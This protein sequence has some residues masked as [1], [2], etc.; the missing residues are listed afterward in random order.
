M[1]LVLQYAWRFQP[2][3]DVPYASDPSKSRRPSPANM[4]VSV[5]QTGAYIHI[6]RRPQ[7]ALDLR[8]FHFHPFTKSLVVSSIITNQSAP[9]TIQRFL[10]Q[11]SFN[12]P[13]LNVNGSHRKG[14]C[15]RVRQ[16]FCILLS[17]VYTTTVARSTT[18][19]RR[20]SCGW[21]CCFGG[22]SSH[23]GEKFSAPRS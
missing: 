1:L 21:C 8:I 9:Y 22:Y 23:A 10:L 15:A 5:R 2:Y 4:P 18:L 16:N 14:P 19:G 20:P 12:A 11:N 17:N 3:D 7:D 13:H 6:T